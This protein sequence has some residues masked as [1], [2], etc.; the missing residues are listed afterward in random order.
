MAVRI[1]KILCTRLHEVHRQQAEGT[2]DALS[3]GPEGFYER[4]C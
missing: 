3:Q 4:P 2:M 1:E